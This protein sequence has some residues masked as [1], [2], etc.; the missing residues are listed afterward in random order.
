[1]TRKDLTQR[2]V[3]GLKSAFSSR[4]KALA[5]TSISIIFFILIALSSAIRYSY[6]MFSAGIEYWLTAITFTIRGVY[7]TGGLTEIVLNI[8]YSALIGVI[9]TNTYH[10]FRTS[11]LKIENLSGIAPSFVIAGCAGCGIGILSIVGL[12]G[13]VGSLPFQG[14]SIKVAGILLLIYFTAEIGNPEICSTPSS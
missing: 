8:V 11:G 7:L 1:M 3:Q 5:T 10:Q 4:K 9:I 2:L 6:Q 12:A 13:I 14:T